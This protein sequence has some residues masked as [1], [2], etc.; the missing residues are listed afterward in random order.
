MLYTWFF[1]SYQSRRF[2]CQRPITGYFGRQ[3]GAWQHFSCAGMCM[4]VLTEYSDEQLPLVLE[5]LERLEA[6]LT[7]AVVSNDPVFTQKVCFPTVCHTT[8]IRVTVTLLSATF[9]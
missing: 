2:H 9:T 4:Q 6:H 8:N 5:A 7:A 3:M 1:T